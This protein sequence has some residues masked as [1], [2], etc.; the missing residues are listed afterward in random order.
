MTTTIIMMFD[1]DCIITTITTTT[2]IILSVLRKTLV[3]R[4]FT[5]VS[6]CVEV[7][8]LFFVLCFQMLLPKVACHGVNVVGAAFGDSLC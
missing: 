5:K 8:L 7:V 1:D 4:G 2:I 6:L 3:H